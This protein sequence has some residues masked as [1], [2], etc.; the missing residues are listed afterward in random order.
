M[1][2]DVDGSEGGLAAPP[3]EHLQIC[4]APL[5]QAG[6]LLKARLHGYT[7]FGASLLLML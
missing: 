5:F 4:Q 2:G 6:G 3:Y 7:E 1:L